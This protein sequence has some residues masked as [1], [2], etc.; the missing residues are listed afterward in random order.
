[1]RVVYEEKSDITERVEEAILTANY[2]NEIIE[3]I[4]LSKEDFTALYTDNYEWSPNGRGKPSL[5]VGNYSPFR[6]K[7]VLI[8]V[9]GD[10]EDGGSQEEDF[11]SIFEETFGHLFSKSK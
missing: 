11:S 4:V 8:E 2:E 9:E 7:G 3:R 6:Y 1:M 5:N 10:E